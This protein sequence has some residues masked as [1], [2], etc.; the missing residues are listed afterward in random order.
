[1][2][3]LKRSIKTKQKCYMEDSF[4]IHIKNEDFYEDIDN[5]FEKW[6]DNLTMIKM[7]K[8]HFQ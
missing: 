2:I 7:I 5:D 3:M 1:M 6:F 8:E 4:N